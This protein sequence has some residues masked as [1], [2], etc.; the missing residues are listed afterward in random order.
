MTFPAEAAPGCR[1]A[2]LVEPDPVVALDVEAG[3]AAAGFAPVVVCET[4]EAA[5]RAL[6]AQ[7]FVC[8]VLAADDAPGG[9]TAA[10]CRAAACPAILLTTRST[11][12]LS[13]FDGLA[14]HIV[15]KPF[16]SQA[17]SDLARK[18]AAT[19]LRPRQTA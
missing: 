7:S 1:A 14:A 5:G 17:L 16:S 9:A 15:H 8:L 19:S 13:A 3:L 18:L 10:L 6:Q 2:L 11:G 12:E 4:L